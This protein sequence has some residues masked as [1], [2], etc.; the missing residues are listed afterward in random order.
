MTRPLVTAVLLLSSA[1]PAQRPVEPPAFNSIHVRN[2]GHV[3]VRYA[4]AQRVNLVKGS[5][6]YSR[7]T[8]SNGVL[9]ID[10]C[11]VKCPRGYELEVA[12]QT[13][14]ITAVS[15]ANG[16]EL[17]MRGSFPR[18]RELA[19]GVSNGGIIDARSIVADCVTASV[20]Q[21]G[22]ILTVAEG[23]LSATITHGGVVTYWGNARVTPSVE[24]GRIVRRGDPRDIDTPLSDWNERYRSS[25]LET[26]SRRF[27]IQRTP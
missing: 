23:S 18:Q 16:G 20:N 4:T 1:Q 5:V 3:S 17:I 14:I 24:D 6:S 15:L 13:P 19:I 9:V 22:R 27:A 10:R 21:G 26:H 12:I 25:G 11:S 7:V 8:I 2:S